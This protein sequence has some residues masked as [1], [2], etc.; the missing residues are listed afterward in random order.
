VSRLVRLQGT[1]RSSVFMTGGPFTLMI[2]SSGMSPTTSTSPHARACSTHPAKHPVSQ[3]SS[4]TVV[5]AAVVVRRRHSA[6]PPADGPYAKGPRAP[7]A[8]LCDES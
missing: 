7:C 4:L 1:Y 2:S 8:D 6:H 3:P 5:V